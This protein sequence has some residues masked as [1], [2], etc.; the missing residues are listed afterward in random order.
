VV[1]SHAGTQRADQMP[2]TPDRPHP[3]H[4]G[5]ALRSRWRETGA[6]E[7]EAPVVD[8]TIAALPRAPA[9]HSTSTLVQFGG[10]ALAPTDRKKTHSSAARSLRLQTNAS[11]KKSR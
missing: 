9:V 8:R 5:S 4:G 10:I 11:N 3:Q 2:R 1:T 7:I 6:D